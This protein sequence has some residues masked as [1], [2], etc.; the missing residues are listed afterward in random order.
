[1]RFRSLVVAVA[2]A[3]GCGFQ[4]GTF[5][6]R[7]GGGEDGAQG[8]HDANK[9]DACTGCPANDVPGGA[10]QLTGTMTLTADLASAHDDV[11]VSC[12]GAGGRDLY[13]QLVVPT[14]QVV[15]LDTSLST[16]DTAVALYAG[17][18]LATQTETTCSNDPC[19][20]A[21]YSIIARNLA[22]GTYCVVVDEATVTG[23]A[24][25][26]DVFFADREGTELTGTPPYVVS[27]DTCT[28]TDVT[29]PPCEGTPTNA[30]ASKDQMYWYTKCA[31][32]TTPIAST[33]DDA[34]YDSI[35]TIRGRA[36]TTFCEDDGCGLFSTASY[37]EATAGIGGPTLVQVTVDGYDT[38]CGTYTLTVTP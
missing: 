32:T 9:L 17:P 26:L 15:Y 3:S 7:D 23:T 20:G 33:C 34:A 14:A 25:R 10:I 5:M 16:A 36:T 35:L 30:G 31:G 18:C 38:D 2:L 22:A 11:A 24:V 13:Y 6:S 12:G 4:H 27:G 37:V 19:A 1:V 28:G 21:T 29:D 8:P